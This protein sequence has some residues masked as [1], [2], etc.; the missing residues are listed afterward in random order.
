MKIHDRV[1]MFLAAL[2][3]DLE[4]LPECS[5]TAAETSQEIIHEIFNRGNCGNLAVMMS[6]AFAGDPIEIKG[7]SHIVCR[8]NGRLYDITGDVTAKHAF[9]DKIIRTVQWVI[10]RSQMYSNYSFEDRDAAG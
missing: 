8:V 1:M 7:H 9:D 3:G 10:H 2:R 4:A 5:I 6:L